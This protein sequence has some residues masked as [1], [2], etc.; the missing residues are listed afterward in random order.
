MF[1]MDPGLRRDGHIHVL[2]EEQTA[3][4]AVSAFSRYALVNCNPAPNLM[5]NKI[6]PYAVF[7][8]IALGTAPAARAQD[9]TQAT[10]V[11][12]DAPKPAKKRSDRNIITRDDMIAGNYSSAYDAVAGM[13]SMW[14]RP[15]GSGSQSDRS[16]VWVYID[17]V[18]VGGTEALQ[19]IQPRLVN[20]IRY[21]D[22]PS[23][24]SRWGVDHSAGVIFVSTFK[25]G[26]PAE[27]GADTTRRKP[28]R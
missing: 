26:A 4:S 21:Y 23:A 5:P 13:R 6:I 14:L 28:D 18:R 25:E 12:K 15:R 11:Q 9:S 17:N 3:F 19:T 7:A 2:F 22:G 8:A 20:T 27:H 1:T 16:T 10:P 24:T